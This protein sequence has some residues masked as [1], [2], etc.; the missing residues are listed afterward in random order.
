MKKQYQPNDPQLDYSYGMIKI[1]QLRQRAH[2]ALLA[3][4]W[5]EVCDIADEIVLAAR[6]VKLYC[7]NELDAQ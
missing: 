7:L 3:K 5:S 6:S 1:Q 4:R 2:T